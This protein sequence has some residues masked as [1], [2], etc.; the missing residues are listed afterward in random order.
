M[1]LAQC[2]RQQ[3]FIL[4]HIVLPSDVKP[5]LTILTSSIMATIEEVGHSPHVKQWKLAST[6]YLVHYGTGEQVAIPGP[7]S[8]LHFSAQ[9]RAFIAS[10]TSTGHRD[11]VWANDLLCLSLHKATYP[12]GTERMLIQRKGAGSRWLEQVEKELA[13]YTVCIENVSSQMMRVD[14][15]IYKHALPK[16]GCWIYITLPRLVLCCFGENPRKFIA[17]RT[18]MWQQRIEKLLGQT[19][20][21]S[22]RRSIQSAD[23]VHVKGHTLT[24]NQPLDDEEAPSI[25]LLHLP[26]WLASLAYSAQSTKVIGRASNHGRP[27]CL[28]RAL[29]QKGL[30]TIEWHISDHNLSIHWHVRGQHCT[31]VLIAAMRSDP[32]WRPF[33]TTMFQSW[34]VDGLEVTDMILGLVRM[35]SIERHTQGFK[36]KANRLLVAITKSLHEA[37]DRGLSLSLS[38]DMMDM[39]IASS[40]GRAVRIESQVK[41]G[42]VEAARASKSRNKRAFVSG[43]AAIIKRRKVAVGTRSEHALPG[44]FADSLDNHS[45]SRHWLGGRSM[46]DDMVVCCLAF[47]GCKVAGEEIISVACMDA[48]NNTSTWLPVQ[49]VLS[50]VELAAA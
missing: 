45:I 8:T 30:A 38:T 19:G 44:S 13:T 22:I 17:N 7:S 41:A 9:D 39:P 34:S 24:F 11:V 25:S 20:L 43:M 35:L 12:D 32:I 31:P 26:I 2:K 33:W 10:V 28:L 18:Q 6:S 23:I 3:Q 1:S 21:G 5:P 50:S 47:D 36:A 40:Q 29:L 49:V 37:M 4:P 16:D 46:A 42:I 48:A 14:L 27:A 15:C